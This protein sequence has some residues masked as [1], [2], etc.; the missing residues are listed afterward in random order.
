[1]ADIAYYY[2]VNPDQ[3]PTGAQ[4]ATGYQGPTGPQGP[5]GPTGYQGS[6]G[7]EGPSGS[8]GPPGYQGM[9]GQ[10]GDQGKPGRAGRAG[11]AG[12][13][14][15]TLHVAWCDF[16]YGG[17]T[18]G[19]GM[20]NCAQS[21]SFTETNANV[22]LYTSSSQVGPTTPLDND[23]T[24][25][26]PLYTWYRWKG[27]Q[28][29]VG[30][31]GADSNIQ[32]PTGSQGDEGDTGSQ[33]DDGNQGFQGDSGSQ[34]DIGDT[35]SQGDEGDTGSQGNEGDKGF[36][37][38]QG[39]TGPLGDIGPQGDEGDTGS[40]GEEGPQG[41]TFYGGPQGDTG[42]PGPTG[43]ADISI[44]KHSVD[45]PYDENGLFYQQMTCPNNGTMT[46]I[47][48]SGFSVAQYDESWET[49]GCSTAFFPPDGNENIYGYGS[50]IADA[51]PKYQLTCECQ[52]LCQ[53]SL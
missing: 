36:Q 5:E 46:G 26:V 24:N 43:P 6:I 38:N 39:R 19:D 52:V 8:M 50:C 4:G 44:L 28:G 12:R 7:E 34:G 41:P 17:E 37:G 47:Y 49:W 22:G 48:V 53:N 25:I 16:E 45:G 35:G 15:T 31:T 3:G 11:R 13:P 23:F 9:K 33:G 20:Y 27:I 40:Q 29:D 2:A 1:M 21:F 30:P 32:G 42:D 51:N 14:G 10:P 18:G